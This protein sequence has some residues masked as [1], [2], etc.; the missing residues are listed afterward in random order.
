MRLVYR[1]AGYAQL[2]ALPLGLLGC[3][4]KPRDSAA[5][6]ESAQELIMGL[7]MGFYNGEEWDDN[8]MIM[9]L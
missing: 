1:F 4:G 6:A 5:G 8:G 2:Q 7:I 9:G 3:H